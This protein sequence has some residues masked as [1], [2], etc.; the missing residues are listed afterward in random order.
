MRLLLR[1]FARTKAPCQRTGKAF[2]RG[3][4]TRIGPKDEKNERVPG[5]RA[6]LPVAAPQ[7]AGGFYGKNPV[8]KQPQGEVPTCYSF[9]LKLSPLI[10]SL[11]DKVF[12]KSL[13]GFE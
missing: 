13:G 1:S 8:G 5:A 7:C 10:I 2:I 3:K 11:H 6:T 9:D 4:P 12:R